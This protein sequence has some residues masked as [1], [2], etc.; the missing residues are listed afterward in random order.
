MDGYPP[1]LELVGLAGAGKTTLERILAQRNRKIQVIQLPRKTSYIP[2]LVGNAVTWLPTY[3]RY[4]R[5][6]RWFTW[7]E[8][9]LMAYLQVW[10]SVLRQGAHD[11]GTVTVINPGSVYWLAALREF[12]PEI[13]RSSP[14]ERWWIS[15][16]SQWAAIVS[17]FIW[18]DAPD[19]VLME[20]VHARDGWHEV[21]EQSPQEALDCFARLRTWYGQ[22]ISAMSSIGGSQ[23]LYYRTD[24]TSPGQIAHSVLA[25]LDGRV[26][27]SSRPA[28]RCPAL[29]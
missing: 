20:R 18:L 14:Y 10:P 1:V 9:K 2:F 29:R 26:D 3:L 7:K 17:L 27:W 5:N 8:T 22:L 11:R 25:A 16:F 23:V 13:S 4:Y 12:G 6:T 28:G 21:K 24:Q 15:A 19:K